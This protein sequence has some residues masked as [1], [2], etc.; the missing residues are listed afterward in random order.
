MMAPMLS[1]IVVIVLHPVWCYLLVFKADMGIQGVGVAGIITDLSVYLFLLAYS[2]LNSDV[3]AC[4]FW[5]DKRMF[6]ELK[7]FM[8]LG[9]PSCFMLC[10]DV[11][12]GSSITI[13]AGYV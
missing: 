8:N 13:I 5:P 3:K 2:N 11:Y 10:L 1:Q 9:L 12:A 4:C 7:E 6:E